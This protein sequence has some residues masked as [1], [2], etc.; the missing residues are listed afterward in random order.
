VILDRR[1]GT[2]HLF[3][4]R[5][6]AERIYVFEQSGLTF[7]ASEAKALLAV[8]PD[9]R[10]FDQVG[11]SDFIAF[12]S[13]RH[14]RT[15]FKGVALMPGGSLWS[16]G[17]NRGLVKQ[18]YFVPSVW[19]EQSPL[20]Q[21]EFDT[22]FS[23]TMKA[24]VPRCFEGTSATGLSIT[25]GLDTRMI[26]ACWDGAAMSHPTCYT[27]APPSGETLDVR[28]GRVVAQ[29]C[30]LEHH[31]L[32][33]GS[34]FIAGFQEH[35]DRTVF[36]TDGC[37]GALGA[38][39]IY[40]SKLARVLSPIRVTGNFGSEVLRGVSTLKPIAMRPGLVARDFSV[41]SESR[42]AEAGPMHPVTR[43]A[44]CEVPWHLFGTMAAARSELVFRTPYLD[45]ELVE[46]AYRAPNGSRESPDTA[47]RF[48][49]AASPTLAGIPTDRGVLAG[50]SG[51][52]RFARRAAAEVAF[53]LDYLHKEGL[54]A[55]LSRLEFVFDALEHYGALG[56]HK[57][58]PYRLWFQRELRHCATDAVARAA[59]ANQPFW[60][61]SELAAVAEDH[62]RGRGNYLRELNAILTL[63]AVD[64]LL[65]RDAWRPAVAH[66][67]ADVA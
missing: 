66:F 57:Y 18:R 25:G 7:F 41:S 43:A 26:L 50:E 30:G 45:N 53:K 9:C 47:L 16:F 48:L 14:G 44:F 62:A 33:L 36:V 65:L 11:V 49:A 10:S 56:Q 55:S 27:F 12:G 38:H 23:A 40:F 35:V 29:S 19:E 60:E 51:I 15:L 28:L 59:A 58:L 32:R 34:D 24:I 39:E 8:L 31:A 63:E 1:D 21:R 20:G 22:A 6:S 64:R 54:P 5:Y 17:R 46:L 52:R 2:A 4:D 37:A 42:L 13:T 61:S 67:E 3:N